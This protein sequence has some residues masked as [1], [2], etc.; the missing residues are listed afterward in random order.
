MLIM[1][2]GC[3]TQSTPPADFWGGIGFAYEAKRGS[4]AK[5]RATTTIGFEKELGNGF[6]I[7]GEVSGQKL[8]DD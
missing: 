2:G 8:N 1:L 5:N 4:D 3:A 6:G 7:G